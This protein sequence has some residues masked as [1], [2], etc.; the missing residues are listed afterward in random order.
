MNAAYEKLIQHLDNQ[1]IGY[2]SRT[3]DRSIMADLRGTVA[4]YRVYAQVDA[5]HRLFQV[6][7]WSPL[8]MPKGARAGDRRSTRPGQ[9]RTVGRQV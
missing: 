4:L 8:R 3:E 6:C 7:G 5:D 2:W 1:N 9:F